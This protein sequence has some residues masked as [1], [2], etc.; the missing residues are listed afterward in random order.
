VNYALRFKVNIGSKGPYIWFCGE[1]CALS[2]RPLIMIDV[3]KKSADDK[4]AVSKSAIVS[5]IVLH[6]RCM[7]LCGNNMI[8]I[9]IT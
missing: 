9:Q 3:R 2:I 7:K 1:N 4:L 6:E 5:L 8:M